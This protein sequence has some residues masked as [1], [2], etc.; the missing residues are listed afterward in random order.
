MKVHGLWRKSFGIKQMY[1]ITS[2]FRRIEALNQ[3]IIRDITDWSGKIGRDILSI[4]GE[5]L[6]VNRNGTGRIPSDILHIV[7]IPVN[8]SHHSFTTGVSPIPEAICLIYLSAAS[9]L[10]SISPS[11]IAFLTASLSMPIVLHGSIPNRV[12]T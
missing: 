11:S 7:D 1:L 6:S 8:E 3:F 2:Q 12:I 5:H 4:P 10:F 9:K